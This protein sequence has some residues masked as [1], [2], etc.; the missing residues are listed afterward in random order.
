MALE[1]YGG[2]DVS[3]KAENTLV[4][5]QFYAVELSGAGLQV[6]VPDGATDLVFGVVQNECP[7]GGAATVRVQGITMWVSDGN[8]S[9]IA[10]GARVG[11]DAAGKAVVKTTDTDNVAG[12]ALSP[13]TADGTVIDVLLT[14]GVSL[15]A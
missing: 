2:L 6:D 15:S 8:A 12:I 7:A 9:A 14:P 4:A 3:C 1:L 10:V 5:K 13:S 11:T